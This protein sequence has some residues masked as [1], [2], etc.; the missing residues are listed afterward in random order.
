MI[1]NYLIL[2]SKRPNGKQIRAWGTILL[3]HPAMLLLR[4]R[5]M[6]GHGKF[7]LIFRE[8]LINKRM[9]M[10]MMAYFADTAYIIGVGQSKLSMVH[11]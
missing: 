5:P 2:S 6:M 4:K 10:M 1:I 11:S 7:S 9:E 8:K 3:H